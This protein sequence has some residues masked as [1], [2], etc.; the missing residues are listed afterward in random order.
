MDTRGTCWLILSSTWRR[1]DEAEEATSNAL[2]LCPEERRHFP[3]CTL[4]RLDKLRGDYERAA[5]WFRKAIE[6]APTD[7]QGYIYLGGILAL[8]GRPREAEDVHRKAT[9]TCYEGCLD[10]AFLNLGFVLRTQERFEEAAECFREAIHRDPG[11]RAAKKALRD[12]ELPPGARPS[13][14]RTRAVMLVQPEPAL[15][16][17]ADTG[18]PRR[19]STD[20]RRGE[21]PE[22]GRKTCRTMKNPPLSSR[23]MPMR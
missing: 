17:E 6:A 5:E 4:G 2:R 21:G 22:E 9:E 10:E 13:L 11:Y 8:Q 23:W 19:R 15:P 18:M 3:L 16:R 20:V 14:L 7:T 12:V 1:Y